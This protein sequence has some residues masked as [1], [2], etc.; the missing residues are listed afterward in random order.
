MTYG[1]MTCKRYK[2]KEKLKYFIIGQ[3]KKEKLNEEFLTLQRDVMVLIT[4]KN[5]LH[6]IFTFNL[7]NLFKQ[8]LLEVLQ[9]EQAHEAVLKKVLDELHQVE[10]SALAAL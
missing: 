6:Q 3:E 4:K 5:Y 1:V 8:E 9:K 2:K 7:L 10:A